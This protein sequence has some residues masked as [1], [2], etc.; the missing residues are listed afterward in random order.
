MGN[1]ANGTYTLQ[2]VVTDAAG[3]VAYSPGVTINLDNSVTTNVLLPS[4]GSWVSGSKVALEAGASDAVGVT[5][6]EFHLT[7]RS[8]HNAL[9]ATATRGSQGW[10]A[11][12]NSTTVPDGTYTLQSVAYDAAG[13]QG[14]RRGSRSSSRT[15]RRLPASMT[16]QWLGVRDRVARASAPANVGVTNVEFHLTGGSLNKAL[17]ATG[18][19]TSIG[20]LAGWNSTTVPDGTYTLQ[21]EAYDGAGLHGFSAGVPSSSR[22]RRPAPAS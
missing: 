14:A 6:V 13:N 21:A 15:R 22:T 18:V 5:K 3:N 7:G 11:S 16:V 8:L 2:S 9:I 17:I 4:S 20:W 10:T 12:W 19:S 1:V